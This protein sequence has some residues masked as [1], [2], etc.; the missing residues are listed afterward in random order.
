MVAGVALG[1]ERSKAATW[2]GP[3]W[4]AAYDPGVLRSS[5]MIPGLIDL[6]DFATRYTA[7]WCS[8]NPARVAAFFSEADR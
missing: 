1:V 3:C 8:R 6:R 5:A 4:P 7:A 2:V